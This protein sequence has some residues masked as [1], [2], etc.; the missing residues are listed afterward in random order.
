[1]EEKN[2]IEVISK[3]KEKKQYDSFIYS[4]PF[5]TG[6]MISSLLLYVELPVDWHLS[7]FGRVAFIK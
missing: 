3:I 2:E 6:A 5:K 7:G 4:L 1:M